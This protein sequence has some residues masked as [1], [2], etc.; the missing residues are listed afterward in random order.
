M[1]NIAMKTSQK[2]SAFP[3]ATDWNTINWYKTEKYVDKLQKRIYRAEVRQYRVPSLFIY[4]YVQ[5]NN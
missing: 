2:K 4:V 1:E 5:W 3:N